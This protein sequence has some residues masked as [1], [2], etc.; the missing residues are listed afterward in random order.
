MVGEEEGERGEGE[1]TDA[2]GKGEEGAKEEE[3][4]REEAECSLKAREEG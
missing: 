3:E 1:A 2:F 4:A